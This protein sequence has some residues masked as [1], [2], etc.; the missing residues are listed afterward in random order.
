LKN[1]LQESTFN[2]NNQTE[3]QN[4]LVSLEQT[5]QERE[6]EIAALKESI[7]QLEDEKLAMEQSGRDAFSREL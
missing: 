5:V 6:K 7:V 2:E 1:A 4:L 3:T